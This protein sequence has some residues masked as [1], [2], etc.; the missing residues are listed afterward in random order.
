LNGFEGTLRQVG[1]DLRTVG[2]D[3]ALVGGLAVS[4]RSEPR[5]TRDV[6]L[7]IAVSD[8][9]AAEH[10]IRELLH[11]GYRSLAIVEH[12]ATGRLATAR[13]TSPVDDETIVDL[14]LAS[15]GIEP[16]VVA[17]A[18]RVEVLDGLMAPVATTGHLITLKLLARDDRAR[19][20]DLLDLRALLAVA[21]PL[22]LDLVRISAL[23]VSARGYDR[24]R[25]LNASLAE[26]IS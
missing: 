26:L 19:P 24:G 20:Q 7:A 21:G 1:V 12:E 10:V 2:V 4:V 23:L 17:Q 25:D 9:A 14:L 6:D 15:S 8:D 5:F 18:E 11:R 16:E 22:D 3:H 13:L